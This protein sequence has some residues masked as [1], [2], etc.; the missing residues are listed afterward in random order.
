VIS[1]IGYVVACCLF[2]GVALSPGQEARPNF[3]IL[4]ADDM[5]WEDCGAYG[6]RAVRTPNIDGLARQG[7]RFDRAILTCSS[8]SPSRASIMTGRYPHNT[9]A[10][11]LHWPLPRT[12]VTFVEKLKASGYWTAAAGKWHVGPQVKDRFDIV[13]EA[14]TAGFQ[15]PADRAGPRGKM[16]DR[17]DESGCANWLPA[18]KSRPKDKPFFLWLAA[19]DPHRDYK[20]NAIANPHPPERV[21]IPPYLPDTAEVRRDL[22]LYYDEIARFD[23]HVGKVLAELEAQGAASNTVVIFMADNGRPFPRCKTTVYDS[24]IKTPLV[25]RWPAKV[26]PGTTCASLISSVDLAPTL[27]ELARVERPPTFQGYSFVR[28]FDDPNSGVREYAFAEH[29]WHDYDAHKRAV[30]TEQ[31]K[32]IRNFDKNFPNTPPADAVRS[33]TF[34]VMRKLREAKKLPPEQMVCFNKPKPEE[35]LYDCAADPHE[36][37]DLAKDPGFADTLKRL[38]AELA[39]WQRETQDPIPGLRNPDEFDR[40]TGEPLPNRKRPRSSKE[41]LLTELKA[42]K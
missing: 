14:G 39:K 15:L 6:N 41:E 33:P 42:K 29:N 35:E 40:E 13:A 20:P 36:L 2:A 17:E 23:E 22:A 19:L 10:E 11:Q 24:G 12:Q 34:Q 3:V 21:V 7:M 28:L 37:R 32:Y 38:R 30:R 27:L 1:R 26:K 9:D 5:G 8:C 4:I 25:I 31:F 18:L 16:I